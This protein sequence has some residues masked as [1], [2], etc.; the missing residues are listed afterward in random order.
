[1]NELKVGLFAL[2]TL[3]AVVYMSLK[4]TSTQSGFGDYI[5]YRTIVEDASGIFPKTSIKVAG[6]TAGRI[7]NIELQGNQALITFQV[8]TKVK[9]TEGSKLRIKS[10][11]FLGDK[12]LEI[13]INYQ[14]DVRLKEMELIESESKGGLENLAKDASELLK[15]VREVVLSVKNSLSPKGEKPPLEEIMKDI[16]ETVNNTKKIT[17]SLKNVITGNEKK[18]NSMISNLE[19]FSKNL[20]DQLDKTKADSTLSELHQILASVKDTTN[21]LNALMADLRNGKGTLGKLLVEEEIA[22]EVRETLAGVKKIVTKVDSVRT[23]LS[24]F[25]G[26]DT[27]HGGTTD[28]QLILFP[29]PER[30]Y[31]LGIVT[32]KIG[33]TKEKETVTSVNGGTET[34]EIRK[35]TDKDTYRFNVQLGR[36]VHNWSFRG[37]L[38]ESSGGVGIDYDISSLGTRFSAEAFDYRKNIGVNFRLSSEVHLWNVFYGRLVA[39]DIAEDLR[40][41]TISGGLRFTDEDLKGLL[42]FFI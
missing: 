6:I 16:R 34:T 23:E 7:K 26:V 41:F 36:R 39:E 12:Y 28:A 9:V 33:P 21:D 14:N 38:I 13:L 19:S 37:G 40:S 5:D 27:E 25:T 3:V 29:S 42:G 24:L 20:N 11:G 18:L 1:M 15:D 17:A 22:D 30:F 31:Q 4:V 8:L 35:E 2:A 32:S 10:V